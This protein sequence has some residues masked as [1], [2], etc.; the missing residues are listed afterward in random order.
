[1][2][3]TLTLA[4]SFVLATAFAAGAQAQTTSDLL[5][6]DNPSGIRGE[7]TGE[8]SFVAP[9]PYIAR[10]ATPALS[11]VYTF[12]NGAEA[13]L[14]TSGLDPNVDIWLLTDEIKDATDPNTSTLRIEFQGR[15]KSDN[16]TLANPIGNGEMVSSPLP[17]SIAPPPSLINSVK[18]NVGGSGNDRLNTTFFND[19][20][21]VIN[22]AMGGIRSTN[23]TADTLPFAVTT[24]IDTN[25][26][27][28]QLSTP[29]TALGA[30]DLSTYDTS[31]LGGGFSGEIAGYFIEI[32]VTTVPEPTSLALLSLAGLGMIGAV[33]RR[34]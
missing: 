32:N 22:S 26:F 13:N 20:T 6:E 7:F 27:F 23:D 8:L 11:T 18:I 12:T 30:S 33:R 19:P 24:G 2:K 9:G 16:I 10:R 25:G 31:N 14:G 29:L 21:Y 5:F 3:K 28:A 1:M 4:A 34:C 17:P 15:L